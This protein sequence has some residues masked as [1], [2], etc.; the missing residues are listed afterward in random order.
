MSGGIESTKPLWVFDLAGSVPVPAE[1]REAVIR[2]RGGLGDRVFS[3][4]ELGWPGSYLFTWQANGW[5]EQKRML[6][7]AGR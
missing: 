4:F 6:L 7:G 3:W 2:E 5:R 1:E